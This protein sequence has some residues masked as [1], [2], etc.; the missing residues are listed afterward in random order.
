[1]MSTSI[2]IC[3]GYLL[4]SPHSSDS[5]KYPE[6]MFYEGIRIKQGILYVMS[7]RILY[8]SKSVLMTTSLGTNA[9]VIT[10][11][12]YFSSVFKE[13]MSNNKLTG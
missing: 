8:N 5:I 11:F 13:T 7:L 10:S 1:M 9:V 6:H 3:F 2:N 12:T 4:Q